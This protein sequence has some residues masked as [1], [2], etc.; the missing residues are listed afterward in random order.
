MSLWSHGND[1]EVYRAQHLFCY[2][3]DE[4]LA[5]LAPAPSSKKDTVSLELPG[6]GDDLLG[7][8][9]LANNGVAGDLLRA[10]HHSPRLKCFDGEVNRGC[11]VVVGHTDGISGDACSSTEDVQEDDS[12]FGLMCLLERKRH[13]PFQVAE[14]SRDEDDGGMSP[15]AWFRMRH[16]A[17][18]MRKG[19]HRRQG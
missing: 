19:S 3:A 14:V 15:S 18:S 4:Q 9:A 2:R 1:R 11:R 17:Q 16:G 7:R 10:D 6:C 12:C 8:M 13:E 5:Y